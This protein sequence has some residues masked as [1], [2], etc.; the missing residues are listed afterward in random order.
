VYVYVYSL[1]ARDIIDISLAY[2]A[3]HHDKPGFISYMIYAE[4]R[5]ECFKHNFFQLDNFNDLVIWLK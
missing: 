5:C 1:V 3:K 4:K 2:I